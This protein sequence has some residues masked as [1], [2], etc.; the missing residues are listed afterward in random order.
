[1]S[2]KAPST[3]INMFL[4]LTVIAVV[5]AAVL[6]LV[7]GVTAEP[8]RDAEKQKTEKALKEV[9]PEFASSQT[10]TVAVGECKFPCTK[11]FDQNNSLVGVAVVAT[12][13]KG[14]GGD[15]GVMFGFTPEGDINGYKVLNTSETP[16]LGAKA[17]EWFQKDGKG[18]VIGKNP[19]SANMTV[20]KD[21]GEVDAISGSTITSRAFCDAIAL[22]YSAFESVTK[23]GNE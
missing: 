14:F 7:S 6:A 5:A 11:V 12:S 18:C 13:K 1:M 3:L 16:G 23:G 10:D 17:A 15:L 2:K 22:A 8:I 9:L 4:S 20:K 19:K 21:G